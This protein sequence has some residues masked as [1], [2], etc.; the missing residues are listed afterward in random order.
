[1]EDAIGAVPALDIVDEQ[2]ILM[3]QVEPAGRR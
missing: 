2:G 1:V 3:A